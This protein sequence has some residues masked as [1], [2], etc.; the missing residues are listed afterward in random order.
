M[1]MVWG[2]NNQSC[3]RSCFSVPPIPHCDHYN[4]SKVKTWHPLLADIQCL[5]KT[6]EKLPSDLTLNP[7]SGVTLMTSHLCTSNTGVF[8]TYWS[9][10]HFTYFLTLSLYPHMPLSLLFRAPI[11][12]K[13]LL[14]L[15]QLKY[16]FFWNY[17]LL[18]SFYGLDLV[19]PFCASIFFSEHTFLL[20]SDFHSSPL[21]ICPSPARST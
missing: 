2:M 18:L 19:A 4:G 1:E 5:L 20:L 14:F 12:T 3:P 15:S 10:S 21:N 11:S 9:S 8:H 7:V 6:S 16:H 17:F 13:L